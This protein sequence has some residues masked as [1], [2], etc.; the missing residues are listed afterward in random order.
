MHI[1]LHSPVAVM[2][3]F[4]LILTLAAC[5][6]PEPTPPADDILP[7]TAE[8]TMEPVIPTGTE[9]PLPTA[10][11]APSYSIYG[12]WVPDGDTTTVLINQPPAGQF[13]TPSAS[14]WMPEIIIEPTSDPTVARIYGMHEHLEYRDLPL[15]L[16]QMRI[17]DNFYMPEIN[18][19]LVLILQLEPDGRLYHEEQ[20]LIGE[21]V[22]CSASVYYVSAGD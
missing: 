14:M 21:I 9:P 7:D 11:D 3:V 2:M 6:K 22:Y 4:V 10:T 1:M 8:P 12:T 5:A 16:Q 15:D 13:C 17:I 20:N 19:T 18:Q